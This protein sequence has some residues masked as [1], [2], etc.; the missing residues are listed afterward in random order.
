MLLMRLPGGGR[1][2]L[3]RE[4]VSRGAVFIRARRNCL[5]QPAEAS[6]LY[7]RAPGMNRLVVALDCSELPLGL[8]TQDQGESASGSPGEPRT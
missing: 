5:T 2:K 6:N 4:P 7:S 8:L 1:S 3:A